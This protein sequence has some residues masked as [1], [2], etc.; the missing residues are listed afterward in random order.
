MESNQLD[1][2]ILGTLLDVCTQ[3]FKQNNSQFVIYLT[4]KLISKIFKNG[5]TVIDYQI[6]L[7]WTFEEAFVESSSLHSLLLKIIIEKV[8]R[9]EELQLSANITFI[10]YLA[11]IIPIFTNFLESGRPLNDKMQ[12]NTYLTLKLYKDLTLKCKEELES[13]D[14]LKIFETFHYSSLCWMKKL[15]KH[16]KKLDNGFDWR[17]FS[18][19]WKVISRIHIANSQSYRVK[20]FSQCIIQTFFTKVTKVHLCESS[21]CGS[22]ADKVLVTSN[23]LGG[24]EIIVEKHVARSLL[25]SLMNSIIFGF[26]VSKLNGMLFLIFLIFLSYM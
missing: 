4:E 23:T 16:T 14:I 25:L 6:S 2:D 11:K 20:E 22:F 10:V 26:N 15:V 13:C 9:S 17:A 19:I 8:K 18:Q 1:R 21:L 3:I 7:G 5:I 24:N 12:Q